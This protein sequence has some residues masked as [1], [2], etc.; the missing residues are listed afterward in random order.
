MPKRLS[1]PRTARKFGAEGIG[2]CRTE[3]MFFDS[4]RITFMREMIIADD[5][6]T[7]RAALAKLEPMQKKD[8][9]ELVHDYGRA[10][11]HDP[12]ARP[13]FA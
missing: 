6:K 11:G 9:V 5:E 13:A 4:D 8:F 3:H 10:A 1:T 2:L 12:I 7:R